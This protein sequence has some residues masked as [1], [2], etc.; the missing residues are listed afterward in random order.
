MEAPR[1]GGGDGAGGGV[2]KG[3]NF[4]NTLIFLQNFTVS[5]A[6]NNMFA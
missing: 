6:I 1:R 3:S 2:S 5:N 4:A